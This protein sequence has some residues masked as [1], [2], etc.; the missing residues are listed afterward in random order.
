MISAHT[1]A[2]L[3]GYFRIEWRLAAQR[4]LAMAEARPFLLPIVIDGIPD[5]EAH[6]PEEFR[7]VQWTRPTDAEALAEFARRA[8]Q[9][10]EIA[11]SAPPFALGSRAPF[12]GE[13]RATTRTLQVE[14]SISF[15]P[16]RLG[17]GAAV[18]GALGIGAYLL[19][20][21][22]SPAPPARSTAGGVA[23]APAAPVAPANPAA[24]P[25]E[26]APPKSLVVLPFA[27]LGDKENEYFSDGISEDLLNLLA[28]LPGLRVAARTSAFYFK[29][30]Q[31]P[32][33]EIARQLGVAYVLEG[34]VR[35]VGER[36]RITAQLVKAAD[37][38]PVWSDAFDRALKDIFA[39]QDE[40]T[41]LIA[42]NLRLEIGL[43]APTRGVV[44][45][46]AYQV[47]LQG[48][49]A[50]NLRTP[51]DLERAEQ[52]FDRALA[53][54]AKFARAHLGRA[55][56]WSIRGMER[57]D[58]VEFGQRNAAAQARIVAEIDQ[59]LALEP[60]LAEAH[61]SL[62]NIH[63]LS[64]RF[65]DA[66]RELRRA[67]TLDPNT[68][69]AHLWLGRV[70]QADGRLD[71]ALLAIK[72]AVELDP[73]SSRLLDNY[74]NGLLLAGRL[75][76]GLAAAER[77]TALQPDNIQALARQ[78]TALADLGRKDEAVAVARR[79]LAAVPM[80]VVEAGYALA[81]CGLTAE[82]EQAYARLLEINARG[83]VKAYVLAALGRWEECLQAL[84]PSVLQASIV[85]YL[86]YWPIFDPIRTDPR[87]LRVIAAVGADAAYARAQAERAAWHR[88]KGARK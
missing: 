72:S 24:P 31:V 73:L 81:R 29:D 22:G 59:A 40:I 42:Q 87:F 49:Q 85:D 21:S 34:S 84:E 1:Q 88:S 79:L 33:A 46:A 8:R 27:N 10:L 4:T 9:L 80:R 52:C 2:R 65:A 37:G 69:T 36:V 76:E 43:P 82:A 3:E 51:A 67:L 26:A 74:A 61:A 44:S 11:G 66:E 18:I 6:V 75:A 30:K 20:R 71:E 60:D 48:R 50:W 32:V 19:W 77:A 54:D 28:R 39:V 25:L 45:D 16:A 57:Q 56:V 14:K 53:I 47:Y 5:A 15:S 70:L 12:Q 55:D 78:A 38:F 41:G 62:G 7:A 58:I 23:S 83:I 68:A 17:L 64:W 86:Y 35:R 63:W 13:P